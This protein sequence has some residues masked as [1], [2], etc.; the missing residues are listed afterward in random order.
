MA[1]R[2]SIDFLPSVFRT[3]TNQRFLNA[4]VDQLIQEPSL[5]KIYGY[6]GQQDQSSVFR[7]SDYYI[8]ENDSYSQFYQLEPGVVIKK[9]Q[10]NSNTFTID[11]IYN[12]PDLLNQLVSSGAITNDHQRL[13]SNRYYSY[14]GFVDLDKLT[15]YRQYYWVPTGPLPVDVTASGI[16]LIKEFNVH[17]ISYTAN[18]QTELQSASIGQS[19]Y[20]IDGYENIVNPTITLQRGGRYTFNLGQKG[21]KFYIQSEIGTSGVSVVQANINTR[22]VL[23][24]SNNGSESGTLIFNVPLKTAQDSLISLDTIQNIDMI[25]HVPYNAMQG[26]NY[27]TFIQNYNLD[28]VKAFSTITLSIDWP[29]NDGDW[30]DV[31]VNQRS[32]IWQVTIDNNK[33]LPDGVTN[34]PNYRN[35]SLVYLNDWAEN[36]K[37]FVNQG[38]KYGHTYV[39]RNS[40]GVITQFPTITAPLST[41]YY[42]DADNPLI[43]GEIR[44][45]D[46][47][48]GTFL[49]I[50]DII[51]HDQYTSP[52][53]IKFSSG[54]KVKFTGVT[55]P[56]EYQNNEY[57]VEGVGTSIKLL[58]YNELVT[59]EIIN[60]NVGDVFGSDT[61]GFDDSNFDGTINAPTQKDYV[62]INRSSADGNSWSRNNRWFHREVL[63]YAA[64]KSN[65]IWNFD[66]AQQAQRPIVEFIPNLKLFDYG[67]NYAGAVTV[68]DSNTTDAFFQIEGQNNYALIKNGKYVSDNRLLQNGQTVIFL[69]D[70]D[71]NVRKTIYQ[72]QSIRPRSSATY[73][74]PTIATSHAGTNT[75]FLADVGNIKVNQKVTSSLIQ[76]TQPAF[77]TT[78]SQ[79]SFFCNLISNLGDFDAYYFNVYLNNVLQTNNVDYSVTYQQSVYYTGSSLVTSTVNT[80][81]S[82]NNI[83]LPTIATT[84]ATVVSGSNIISINSGSG[85]VNG[86]AISGTG[87]PVGTTVISGGGT[88]SLTLSNT[89][90]QSLTSV[91]VT[92][93][94]NI[95]SGQVIVDNGG[96]FQNGTTVISGGGTQ[97]L[98]LSKVATA[99]ASG[100]AINVYQASSSYYNPTINFLNK[101]INSYSFVS[102]AG[103]TAYGLVN[104][105]ISATTN[106]RYDVYVNGT[107]KTITSDYT[108]SADVNGHPIINL[109]SAP[110]T[111]SAVVINNVVTGPA[112]GTTVLVEYIPLS[113]PILPNTTVTSIDSVNN[114][115]YIST[116]INSDIAAGLYLTFDNSS[117]QIHLVP[118]KQVSDGDNVIAMEGEI[119]QGNV[120]F[121]DSGVW[122]LAQLR[123]SRPQF[124]LFDVIDIN[125]F[126]LSDTTVYPSSNFRGSKLFGYA[127]GNL[128]SITDTVLGFPLVRQS[129]GNIGDIVFENYYITDTF[130]Y[131]LNFKDNI[132][133]VSTGFVARINY[134]KNYF[135]ENG[136]TVVSD[137]SKQYITKIFTANE[138]KKNNFDLELVYKHSYYENNIFVYVNGI[139]VPSTA[140]T[141]QIN[142]ITTTIKF[143]TDLAAGD[144]L[145]VKINGVSNIFK[146]NYTMPKN[147][148]NNSENL[149]F[150][151]ITL[152]QIRNHLIEI[153]NNCLNLNGEPAGSNNFRD[154][155]YSNIGGK[156]LQHSSSLRQAS[157]LLANPDVDPVRAITYSEN[158]YQNFKNQLIDLINNKEFPDPKDA[159]GSLDLILS[160]FIKLTN[161]NSTFYY[162]DM[163]ATGSQYITNSYTIQDTTYRSFNLTNTYA[164]KKSSYNAVLVYLTNK[165]YGTRQLLV[166]GVDYT[167]NNFTVTIS[168]TVSIS[169]L[170]TI[171]I[172][173]YASTLGCNVPATPSKLGLYPKFVPQKILDDTYYTP[174]HMIIGHDGSYNLAWNDYRDD[175]LL[176]YEKRVF[177]NIAVDYQNNSD[178]SLV[179][180]VPGAFRVTDYSIVEWTQLLS[181][182]YLSW[183]GQNNVDIFTNN[184]NTNSLFGFNYSKATDKLFG[185]TLPGY[186]RGIYNYFYDTDKPHTNPWEMLGFT[187]KPKWW[188]NRYG[189]A[190]YTSQNITLWGD[191]ELGLIYNGAPN[192]SYIDSKYTRTGLNQIIPVDEHGNLLPPL[193]SLIAEYDSRT[194]NDN[195]R[196]GDQSP[197]E[198]AWRRSSSYPFAMQIAWF[199]AKPAE[200][201]ALNYNSRDVVYNELLGQIINQKTNTRIFDY[202]ITSASEF[203]PGFNVWVRDLLTSNNL[204]V[205]YNWLDIAMNSSFNLVYK[206]SGYTDKSYLTVVADQVS[207]ASTNNSVLIPPENYKIKVTKSAPIGRAIYSAVIV[208]KTST[209]YQI[210]GFDKIRPY[211]LTIPSKASGNSYGLTVGQ[212]TGI[213]YKDAQDTVT[214]FPYGTIF[215][216]HQQVVDFL[217]SYGRYLINQGFIFNDLLADNQTVSDWTLAAKEFLFWDQQ[218]WGNNTVI[219]LTPTGTSVN[220]SNVFGVVDKITNDQSYTKVIDSDGTTLTGRDYRVYRDDNNF[221]ISLKNP[222]KGIH[223]LDIF[224]VQYEHC[225]VFDNSTVFNDILYDEQV[226]SRQFRLRLDGVKTQGWNGSLYAPG[227]LVNYSDVANWTSYT[228]YY[229][230]DIVLFKNQYYAARNFIPGA[231]KFNSTDW[232]KI[233]GDLLK[234]Q[235]I[236]NMTSNAAQFT[237]FY[238]PDTADLNT[239]ADIQSKHA[240]GFQDRQYFTNLGL[241]RTS[242]YKFYLGMITQKGT[243]AVLNAFLRNQQKNIDSEIAVSEQW[244]IKLGN[245]GGTN[246]VDKLDFNIGNSKAINNQYLFEFIDQYDTANNE[247]NSIKPSDLFLAPRTYNANIFAQ[248]EYQKPIVSTAGPVNITDATA[249]VYD[250]N[251]IYN[252]SNLSNIL[253]ESSKIWIAADS[254]NKWGVYRLTQTS[255]VNVTGVNQTGSTEITF[256]TD[257]PHGLN[258]FDYVMIKGAKIV[259]STGT[260][261]VIDLSGFYRVSN[262]P[263]A[264]SFSVKI[265]NNT[266]ISSGKLSAPMFKLINV[267]FGT[268]NDFANFTPTRGWQ[269]SEVVY[270]DNGPSGYQVLQ[271][272]DSW[273]FTETRSPVFTKPSD[274][275]GSSIKV[276]FTQSFA[277]VG[278]AGK[279]TTGQVFIY[280]KNQEN[281]WQELGI[282][283]PEA[284]SSGFGSAVDVNNNNIVVASAPSSNKGSVYTAIAN[285]QAISVNQ[286]IHYDNIYITTSTPVTPYGNSAI[287]VD[288]SYGLANFAAGMRVVG[289]NIAS[290]TVIS[291]LTTGFPY[292]VIGIS[293]NLAVTS[294]TIAGGANIAIY[295]TLN[296]NSALGTSLCASTDGNWLFVG[297]PTLQRV[298]VY[299]Y[300]IVN[301]SN[302]NRVGDGYT[303]IFSYPPT[304]YR[305]NLGPL[306][307]KVYVSGKQ[308]VPYLDYIR[309]PD[310]TDSIAFNTAPANGA[311]ISIVYENYFQEVNQ[312]VT[313]DPT[314]SGFGSSVSCSYDGREVVIGAPYSN[315]AFD[316]TYKNSG[317]AFVYERTVENFISDGISSTFNLSNAFVGSDT[318]TTANLVTYPTVTVDGVATA[319]TFSY[320]NNSVTLSSVPSPDSIVAVSTNQFI[321]T[322]IATSDSGQVGSNFGQVV[323]MSRDSQTLYVSAPGWNYTSYQNGAVF[324]FVNMPK[325]CGIATGTNTNVNMAAN[326]QLRINDFLVTFTGGNAAQCVKDINNANVIGVTASLTP[327]STVQIVSND[328]VAV[329]KLRLR[330]EY[331]DP[332]TAMGIVSWQL[333][334]K[335]FS[336]IIQDSERFG[337]KLSLS[338]DSK[339]VVVGTTLSNNKITTTFDASKTTFDI[340]TI[341]IIDTV[342]TSGSAHIFE[343]IAG[344]SNKIADMG[345]LVYAKLLTQP[346][347]SSL[348]KFS[349]G[350]DVSDNFIFVG[351]PNSKILGNQTGAMYIYYNANSAPVWNTIREPSTAT[352]SRMIDRVYIYNSATSKLIADL[353][354]LDILHNRLPISAESYIDYTI[355]YDPAVYSNVPSTVSFSVDKKN[356]WGEEQVGKLW[357][358]TNSIKYFDNSHGSNLEKFNRWG[359]AFPVSS[360]AIYEW[361]ES[362]LLPKDWAAAYPLNPP[363]YTV[364]DVYSTKTVVD[365]STGLV[366]TKYYFWVRN[367]T[368][369]DSNNV[370]P[371][372]F[373]IQ[374]AISQPKLSAEPFAAVISSNSIALYNITNLINV[375]TNLV[376]EYKNTIKPQLIHNEWTM[377]DDGTD[378]GIAPEF[379]NKINDSLSGQDYSGRVIPDPTLSIGQKYGMDIRP[380]QSLF[381]DQ[382]TA[383]KLYIEKLNEICMKYPMVLTRKSA[384][385]ALNVGEALPLHYTYVTSV[386]NLTELGYLDTNIY[387]AG[388][389]V[390]VVNDSNAKNGWSLY[391]LNVEFPNTRT[392]SIYQVQTYNVNDYWS[393]ADWYSDKYNPEFNITYTID[394]ENQIG[395]LNLNVNDLIYIKNS[396]TTG[397]KIVLVNINGLELIGQ[398][399]ATIQFSSTLYDQIS[400]GQGFQTSSLETVGFASDSN[401]EFSVIFGIVRDLLLVNE[402]RVDWKSILRLLIDT[403]A[404]QHLQ[405][406]WLMKTSFVDIY[407]RVRGL[408]PLPVYLP[409]PESIVTDFFN[410]VK[411]FHTKLKQY[412][413]K[414][415]NNNNIDY[416][417][418]SLTDFDLQPYYNTAI[419]KYRSPQ[420]NNSLDTKILN[421]QSLYQPWKNH[422]T[423]Q[424]LRID[425][426]ANG[427]GYTGSTTVV[428]EGDGT[429]AT[430]KAY[431]L[432]TGVHTIEVTNPGTG[433]THAVAKIYGRGSGAAASVILGNSPVRLLNTNIKFDRYTYFNNISDWKSNKLYTVDTVVVNGAEPYRV[434]T[435]HTSGTTFDFTKFALLRVKVWYPYTEY[436]VNDIVIYQNTSYKAIN[437]FTSIELFDTN[438]L[439]S[440]NG[441][442]LDN[443]ADRIWAYYSP[444]SGMAGRDLAQIMIGME[445]GG[446][447]VKGPN[448]DQTPGYDVNNFDSI[449]YD[450]R[451]QDAGGVFDDYGAQAEDTYIQSAFTDTGLGL[452]PSDIIVLGGEFVDKY[453]SNAP[454]ELIPGIINDTLDIKIKTLPVNSG[455]G[456]IMIFTNQYSVTNS[457]SFD[458]AITGVAWP[459]GGIEKFFIID[460]IAGPI[461]EGVD[462]TVN[463]QNKTINLNY[464][465][466]TT[467]FFYCIMM[468]SNGTNPLFDQDYTAD[469]IQT[470][471]VIPDSILNTVQ[472]AYVKVNG[473]AVSNWVL[474]NKLLN[475]INTLAVRFDTAPVAGS[476]IQVHLYSVA[477]GT[478]A[479]T[480]ITEQTFITSATPNYPA[481]Y[482]YVFSNPEEY[483]E[484][485]S[486]YSI[487]R[488]N[489]S[490]LIPPQQSY[491]VGDA[492]TTAFSLTR[493]YIPDTYV[494][495]TIEIELANYVATISPTAI[496]VIIDGVVQRYNIDYTISADGINMPI[497]VFTAAPALNSKITIS[498]SSNSD[499]TIYGGNNLILNQNIVLNPNSVIT[500]LTRG[501]HDPSQVYTKIF[502]GNA[503]NS[504]VD[505]DLGYDGIGFDDSGFDNELSTNVSNAIY[506]LPFAVTNINQVYVTLKSPGT[507]GGRPL[508][509]YYDYNLVSPTKLAMSNSL[510][511]YTNSTVIVRIYGS[512]IRETTVEFRIF[513]DINNN[514]RYYAVRPSRVTRLS[515][516][517][518]PTD[519]WVYVES[520]ANLQSPNPKTNIAGAILVNGE[521]I[522]YGTVD[523][524]NNRLGNIRRGTAGTGASIHEVGSQV[525]DV[526][527]TLIIPNSSDKVITVDHDTYITNSAGTNVLVPANGT[528]MQGKMFINPSESL[529]TSL[530]QQAKFIREP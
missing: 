517:L 376:I 188:D 212:L 265:V 246:N 230:G 514:T 234:K 10:K 82:N 45:V 55:F 323:Q 300:Q 338:P 253:G 467:T 296:A 24:V 14:N 20:V 184:N 170:D 149:N 441:L 492:V 366:T 252:I 145:F 454:E 151:T 58:K 394:T 66:A 126:S 117:D 402:Y 202:G 345:S 258:T 100:V 199:L 104:T 421:T 129:V 374:T 478:R 398:E 54:L 310:G 346:N 527:S 268:V 210:S 190:P 146:Q 428:I 420:L 144:R 399:N 11:N 475:G 415:D 197:A 124:P 450:L 226:G 422:H 431:I 452:R 344:K 98:Q 214:S 314:V 102:T 389:L 497:V 57:I 96:I 40:N 288:S 189:V 382:Y 301:P 266:T 458:P 471:F 516:V 457:F 113:T 64:D 419:S 425:V 9:R 182:S 354:V 312:I 65:Q 177:N 306:D 324:A 28:G 375:D 290:G 83:N 140:Y 142:N 251:K 357:W 27:D 463:W 468:G 69:N 72:V 313:D 203:V 304:A 91:T 317:K 280:G 227:F 108:V 89:C 508:L 500:V 443:A 5:K 369:V 341:R 38:D 328:Q 165:L 218:N 78:A 138:A 329:N 393:Y 486:A 13:F 499:Y 232:Y 81:N 32:G 141:V 233:S 173:E 455:S 71:P 263:N 506:T 207:P 436:A 42:Q 174:Q 397:W 407:H 216:T 330:N 159:R 223:L 36:T 396:N 391:K 483:Q 73:N 127:I 118:V 371:S 121:Y 175:I 116:A 114:I 156:L 23:G 194:A 342:H 348:D 26:Q 254:E 445:Y 373:E 520:V 47:I 154:I 225:L 395:S 327:T 85:I 503:S 97:T 181:G 92:T 171:S 489:A 260:S 59:P 390:L 438:N 385:Q 264:V 440:Y 469:G 282:L 482:T 33:F 271:N 275:Y 46:P 12:Y 109:N 368:R 262:I 355:N 433:Y 408:D 356:N 495:A 362:S 308:L 423:Y 523:T 448:F 172:Y 257:I 460:R 143:N 103:Q 193:K 139:V 21:H 2:R 325:R 243:Q 319:A 61:I 465:V 161:T 335:L 307:I 135:F 84:Y 152:G 195:W 242:Q 305:M 411:P 430:A 278:A 51:G 446:V 245:Y 276:N 439:V 205:T 180:V 18:N 481:D 209:G 115:V 164:N 480:E 128:T 403:I 53:G 169:R 322:K 237:N 298:F 74:L 484:P 383:R 358:D 332:L 449:E 269:D 90:T 365:H 52:N 79:T 150:N 316:I 387:N 295:P 273:K 267:R 235:L 39:Y 432:N 162:T 476:Y 25:A 384:V 311:A 76:Q 525:D 41:L 119:N 513:K 130:N 4:T 337:E 88:S 215:S 15:N 213:I 437:T 297:E 529:Q 498:D 361:I 401:L 133:N 400:S 418:S 496:L 80:I 519:E 502:S 321:I 284:R 157:L 208:Q 94:A 380:R 206:M 511:L 131:N 442:W 183:S 392:W 178:Y 155:N 211:F 512:T 86:Q 343:Y 191:L 472:Q 6:I 277:A 461:A 168:S 1:K 167:I 507:T 309:N 63:Q 293:S 106:Y 466:N 29:F 136:W 320:A 160:D 352:D 303:T 505:I 429:G 8:N 248:T 291:N 236:P 34:N 101:V 386:A 333:T 326:L 416:A 427:T 220:Y 426:S 50:N 347:I 123:N 256:S 250:I 485:L 31:P 363:L 490:D 244:A 105:S 459:I 35:M 107:L 464:N 179:S 451:T 453:S 413:A 292:N 120:Y 87:I 270:I 474:V 289:A 67:T 255:R 153:G 137:K 339:T 228:D 7:P 528:L 259:A 122:N 493:T 231:V 318:I 359:Q 417:Y 3:K 334:Q 370:R 48:P 518:N 37:T 68:F 406:D 462:Y 281:V 524:V 192:K 377:F 477:V 294:S 456:D 229:T 221:S 491:Y 272:T 148:T 198:T 132:T 166:N 488:L 487:V 44:L 302:S 22:D 158:N 381:S 200:Y 176:E 444:M 249:S 30:L 125:G 412:V 187:E 405:T 110:I 93:Y 196:V 424:I 204:D 240:T 351:S 336:P 134:W 434:I 224:I 185:Q 388:D 510:G 201:C 504:I 95:Q 62:T 494:G 372:A 530:T 16:S 274:L 521:R 186:W 285:S 279:N 75:I 331:G 70:V 299:K 247:L 219:G 261:G 283:T 99:T 447:N 522:T 49:N 340:N 509:P 367:S 501:N 435:A 19:G 111:G 17:R 217:I 287:L 238:D 60:Q 241:D 379:I 473:S 364:N 56:T 286:I 353:P 163:L 526:G 147:I 360:V 515:K 350:V 410:E 414:Y 404:T 479:Y 315:S 409:Q 222:Q 43:Y 349:T 470:D 378:L 239:S 77:T 112:T